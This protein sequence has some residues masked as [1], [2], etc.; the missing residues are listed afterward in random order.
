[1]TNTDPSKLHVGLYIGLITPFQ[2]PKREEA[3]SCQNSW[4]SRDSSQVLQLTLHGLP[5][6]PCCQGLHIFRETIGW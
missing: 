6:V 2:Q 1:M 3:N 5:W 4:F